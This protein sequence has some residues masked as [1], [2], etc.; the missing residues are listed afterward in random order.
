LAHFRFVGGRNPKTRKPEEMESL[1]LFVLKCAAPNPYLKAMQPQEAKS[2]Q[3]RGRHHIIA[4]K[5]PSKTPSRSRPG[6]NA[7]STIA[8][9]C[10]VELRWLS[11]GVTPR[12]PAAICGLAASLAGEIS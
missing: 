8:D 10:L 2:T 3:A 12:K 5:L 9:D 4:G 1:R 6:N 7:K 11:I